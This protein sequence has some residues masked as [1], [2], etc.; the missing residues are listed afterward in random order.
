MRCWILAASISLLGLMSTLVPAPAHA[1]PE[2]EISL[3]GGGTFGGEGEGEDVL[4]AEYQTTW[5][6]GGMIGLRP[7]PDHHQVFFVSYQY[8]AAELDLD[9]WMRPPAKLPIHI[10]VLHGGIEVDGALT[11]RIHP[12]LNLSLGAT[13]YTP[14]VAGTETTW[15]FSTGLRGG[16]KVP[17]TSW[18]GLRVGAGFLATVIP[19]GKGIFCLEGGG[20]CVTAQETIGVYQ[21]EATGGLYL[22]F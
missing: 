5:N 1:R 14:D 22:R 20:A 2:V 13:H 10:G 6:V 19:D 17:I 18:L 16:F 21:G 8:Q 11:S 3:L 12:F 7:R 15:F 4:S 9:I